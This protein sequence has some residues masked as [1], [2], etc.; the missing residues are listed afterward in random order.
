MIY[1]KL[2]LRGADGRS[3]AVGEAVCVED[4]GCGAEGGFWEVVWEVHRGKG[5]E[6]WM[7][8][9]S[10]VVLAWRMYMPGRRTAGLRRRCVE[11]VAGRTNTA[12]GAATEEVNR[13]AFQG[14]CW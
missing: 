10:I 3:P 11:D 1:S 2:V 4:V 12:V 5:T 14:E 7:E 9:L 13:F 6:N 8:G